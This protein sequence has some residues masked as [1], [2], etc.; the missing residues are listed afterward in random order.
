MGQQ[1]FRQY[2]RLGVLPLLIIFGGSVGYMV[3]EDWSWTDAVY[4]TIIT[5]STVGFGEVAE[6]SR[7]GRIFTSALILTGVVS[8]TFVF[9]SVA[10]AVVAGQVSGAWK[11]SKLEKK[12]RQI[13]DHYIICGCG[14]VGAKLVERLKFQDKEVL[15]ID[16]DPETEELVTGGNVFFLLG[17][18]VRE[19]TLREAAIER[20]AGISFCLPS[21]ADNLFGVLSARNLSKDIHIAIRAQNVQSEDKM[22]FAGANT[23]INPTSIAGHAMAMHL[24]QPNAVRIYEFLTIASAQGFVMESIAIGDCPKFANKQIGDLQIQREF[25][26]TLLQIL[27][28]DQTVVP[29]VDST[30][31]VEAGDT[32]LVMGTRDGVSRLCSEL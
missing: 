9:T 5:I 29:V 23:V 20:A 7:Q 6:M 3:L 12:L 1:T 30:T 8:F 13:R 4:M 15:V 31:R 27:R 10:Q 14:R 19:A 18:A 16:T 11:R 22:L 26:L 17:D 32:L 21:D 24:I 2:I 28:H 25:G